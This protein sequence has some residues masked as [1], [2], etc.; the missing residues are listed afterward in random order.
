MKYL[1]IILFLLPITTFAQNAVTPQGNDRTLIIN[2]G[3]YQVDSVLFIPHRSDN[4]WYG[5]H[6]DIRINPQSGNLEYRKAGQWVEVGS[7]AATPKYIVQQFQG[8]PVGSTNH[9]ILAHNAYIS[10]IKVSVN[11]VTIPQT[12]FAP[13]ANEIAILYS[14]Y[15]IDNTDIIEISY[16]YF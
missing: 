12:W 8:R 6:G 4:D 1:F 11:G 3:S 2:K 13:S 7:S 10:S 14:F 9:Y 16:V 5:K 15:P